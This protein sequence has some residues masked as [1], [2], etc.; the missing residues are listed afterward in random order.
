[1]DRLDVG[2][3]RELSRDQIVWFGSLD[4]RLSAAE[5]ARRLR[6]D[7]STVSSRLHA[8]ER[9]GFLVGHE[10]VPS[11]LLF[12]SRIAGGNLRVAALAEKQRILEDLALVPGVISAVDHVGEWLALLFAFESRTELERHRK[13]LSRVSGVGEVSPCVPFRA[14]EPEVTPTSL[15]W[16]VLRALGAAPRRPLRAVAR[17]VP[18]SSKTLARR[19]E[20]L[21]RARAIWYLPLLDF[22]RYTKSTVTRFVVVLRP[23]ADASH[24]AEAA[25][26]IVPE[27]THLTDSTTLVETGQPVPAMLDIIA[28]LESVGQAEDIQAALRGI[29]SVQE[30]EI[31]FPRRF[32]LYRNWFDERTEATISRSERPGRLRQENR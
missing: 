29:D 22:S 13:L 8:W 9:S 20:R 15:D 21:V 7:R 2:I 6:V 1:M 16:R 12:G 32:Y 17:S 19:L 11:P 24:A 14:P 31:L 30:A 23:D 25:A 10:I 18:L 27:L 4:P 28:H 26:K 3:L 5:I